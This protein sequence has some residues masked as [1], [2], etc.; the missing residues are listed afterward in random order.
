LGG[1]RNA[2]SGERAGPTPAHPRA[3]RPERP[4][5]GWR[6]GGRSP[7]LP[8]RSRAGAPDW[9]IAMNTPVNTEKSSTGL[10]TNLAAALAYLLWFVTGI[11]LLIVEKD[12]KFVRYHA[13]QSTLFFL[14]VAVIQ[15]VL[16]AIPILGWIL[17]FLVWVASL[18]AWLV[19]MFKAYQGEKFKLPIVGDLAEQQV[20]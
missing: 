1:S 15:M 8:F 16:W 20:R 19:L 7:A 9:R 18:V 11:L 2:D 12:S 13:M 14:P 17:G 5:R 3:G 4:R 10:D 6:A